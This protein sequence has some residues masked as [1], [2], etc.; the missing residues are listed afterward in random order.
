MLWNEAFKLMKEGNKIKL[1]SWGGYWYWDNKKETIMMQCRPQDCDKGQGPLIDIRDTQR[2]DYTF[3]NIASDEWIIADKENTPVL[4]GEAYFDFGTAL[5]YLKRGL[6]VRRK[7]WYKK[8]Y[9]ELTSDISYELPKV[10]IINCEHKCI[11][12][13][14]FAFF[15][16]SEGQMGRFSESDIL[17][18]DWMFYND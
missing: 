14:T 17:A 1:P 18:D 2:V 12:N 8:Q 13:K 15:G 3:S 10:N 6:K 7:G 9:V 4:G 5:K 11:E 16:T